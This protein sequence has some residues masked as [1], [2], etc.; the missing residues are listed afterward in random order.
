MSVSSG[1][2]PE[3]EL[4]LEMG[5]V[6]RK[7][8]WD[9]KCVTLYLMME[10]LLKQHNDLLN[11]SECD[12]IKFIEDFTQDRDFLGLSVQFMKQMFFVKRFIKGTDLE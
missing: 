9:D 11:S 12:D 4:M 7:L 6:F 3:Q 2:T 5:Q 10:C 1:L 8:D